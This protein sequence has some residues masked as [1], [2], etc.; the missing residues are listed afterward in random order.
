M[1]SGVKF[2]W[3][4]V[5]TWNLKHEAIQLRESRPTGWEAEFSVNTALCLKPQKEGQPGLYK[6]TFSNRLVA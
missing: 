5:G 3:F 2:W 6:T 1:E 4:A